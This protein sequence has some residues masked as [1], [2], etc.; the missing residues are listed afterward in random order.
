MSLASV[1]SVN[2][3]LVERHYLGPCRRG[4]FAW[5]DEHGVMVFAKPASRRLSGSWL[6]L[7]RWCLNGQPNGG[8]QQWARFSRWARVY[9]RQYTTVV[10]YSDPAQGH[11]GALYRACNWLWAPTWHR[12]RPP[13]SGN[14]N[15][16]AKQQSV[17]DRW[18]FPLAFDPERVAMLRIEDDALRRRMPWAEFR[19]DKGGDYKR[20]RAEA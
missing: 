17:K 3:I 9:L 11:T 16:S 13:P 2:P 6:E 5:R 10:S 19:E 4:A 7:T 15:W 8:S 1:K 18:I 14:G 12:L 20:W